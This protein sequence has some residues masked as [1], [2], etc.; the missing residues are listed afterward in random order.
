MATLE[1]GA[2]ATTIV[3]RGPRSRTRG[4]HSGLRRGGASATR[5]RLTR[6]RF[7]QCDL[8]DRPLPRGLGG[9]GA[10]ASRPR[11][12]RRCARVPLSDPRLVAALAT[13]PCGRQRAP[14]RCVPSRG[15]GRRRLRTRQSGVGTRRR[16]QLPHGMHEEA[17]GRAAAVRRGRSRGARTNELPLSPRRAAGGCLYPPASLQYPC[18]AL[19]R[20]HAP[21]ATQRGGSG[22]RTEV[23][24]GDAEP[25]W[26]HHCE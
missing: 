21:Q 15:D 13:R 10:A 18:R 8:S 20:A 23:L 17:P 25:A 2:G 14:R 26:P 11:L 6:R 3:L 7:V 16:R 12:D 19:A 24:P 4:D 9:L 22:E 5:M 1:V